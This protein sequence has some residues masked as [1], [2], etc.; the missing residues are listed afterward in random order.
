MYGNANPFNLS[1]DIVV[2]VHNLRRRRL[3]M[4][5]SHVQVPTGTVISNSN[6]LLRLG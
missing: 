1:D 6:M 3:E 2:L 4:D 5:L